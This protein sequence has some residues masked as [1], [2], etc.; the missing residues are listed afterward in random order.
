MAVMMQHDPTLLL[1]RRKMNIC[2]REYP[3][4]QFELCRERF[5]TT[6]IVIWMD[7]GNY[8]QDSQI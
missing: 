5:D 4:A 8:Y 7:N 3:T 1:Q 2:G 6:T